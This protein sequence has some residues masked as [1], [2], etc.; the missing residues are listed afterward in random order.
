MVNLVKTIELMSKSDKVDPKMLK[1]LEKSLKKSSMEDLNKLRQS[2]LFVSGMI[3]PIHAAV[4]SGFQEILVAVLDTKGVDVEAPAIIDTRVQKVQY[5]AVDLA[6][7]SS[8]SQEDTIITLKLLLEKSPKPFVS[9]IEIETLTAL[10]ISLSL[11]CVVKR[12][13]LDILTFLHS[14]SKADLV[15]LFSPFYSI[16]L[17][18]KFNKEK[19]FTHVLSLAQGVISRRFIFEGK[20]EIN[21][22]EYAR[23]LNRSKMCEQLEQLLETF[24]NDTIE[25]AQGEDQTNEEAEGDPGKNDDL[26]DDEIFE[27][28]PKR[29][30]WNCYMDSCSIRPGKTS[31]C[32]GCRRARYCDKKC[33]EEDWVRH[34][35]FC[36][37]KVNKRAFREF[38]FLSNSIFA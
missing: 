35:K 6:L 5:G 4:M 37:A 38:R 27:S 11:S 14:N 17:S 24:D 21:L 23:M 2:N 33:Q 16:L 8:E 3:A 19:V 28:D 13:D 12:E 1:S 15:E 20:K 26:E 10:P 29:Y 9:S 25:E 31:L 30:C 34:R 18:I 32:T 7:S 22:V 36:E